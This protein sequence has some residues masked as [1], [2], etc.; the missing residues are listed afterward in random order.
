MPDRY[1]LCV[2]CI[3]SG[4][5]LTGL[6][7]P[8]VANAGSAHEFFH[9][10]RHDQWYQI[11]KL[12]EHGFDPNAIDAER[13][14]TGLMLALREEH[15]RAVD[16]LIKA[17][18]LDL[19]AKA[20]NGDTALMIAAFSK[21]KNAVEALLAK[22]ALVNRPG[23]TALHYAAAAGA[24]EIVQLLL[25]HYAYIDAAS[26]NGT[27]PLMMAAR[28]GHVKTVQLLL[29]EGA[30]ATIKNQLGLDAIDLAKK[31][32]H[33]DIAERLNQR[34]TVAS[35]PSPSAPPPPAQ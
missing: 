19:E 21:N 5:L 26:P 13:G 25:N 16:V 23:W 7:V 1:K 15:L 18:G 6:L 4:L 11:Q 8:L 34:L 17:P 29:D 20:L 12:L 9:A 31:F 14:E 24:D 22:E 28:G 3:F 30:D 32:D 33:V 2:R 27:T 10:V 35:P